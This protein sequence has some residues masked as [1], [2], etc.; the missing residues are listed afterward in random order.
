MSAP[1]KAACHVLIIEDEWL[2]A[3]HLAAL[4]EEAG[5]TSVA[6]AGMEDEAVR[7]AHDRTPDIILSDVRLAVGTG[8]RAVRTI[9][10]E[11]GAIPVIF[12]TATPEACRPCEP[13]S[14]ILQKPIDPARLI[15]AFKRLVPST[16]RVTH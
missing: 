9:M 6:L 2:I 4:A 15:E 1:G 11:L 13:S 7:C 10:S 5:A 8:P 12:I 16:A 3:D 14:V